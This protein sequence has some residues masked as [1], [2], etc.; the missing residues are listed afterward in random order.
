MNVILAEKP[1]MGRNI[2]EA[3]GAAKSN[4]GYI[5]L[6]NGDVVTWAIGHII[7][8]KTPDAYEQYKDWSME[9]LPVIPEPMMSEVD[10]DKKDQFKIIKELLAKADC[11]VIATDPAREGEHIG[12]TIISACGYKGKLQRLWISDLTP[13]TIRTGFQQLKDGSETLHLAES[14]KVRAYADYWIGFTA[15]RFFTLAAQE[16][17]SEKAVLSAGRVQTPTLRIVYDREMVIEQFTPQPFYVI[18]ADM[19]AASGSYKA[20]W[21]KDVDEGRIYR[22]ESKEDAEAI[23]KKI[24][25]QTGTVLQYE[26]KQVKRYA[27]QLLQSRS[28]KTA[29]RK[30][31]G[32]SMEKTVKVLQS[33][34]DK[35]FVTYPRT[36]SHHLS[37]N[38]A[39][40]LAERLAAIRVE[41]KYKHLFPDEIRSLKRKSRFVDNSKATEHHAIIPTDINPTGLSED[42]EKLYALILR[43]TLAAHHPEGLDREIEVITGVAGETFYTKAV[44][45]LEDGWRKIMKPEAED[46][47]QEGID[48]AQQPKLPQLQKGDKAT[49]QKT[50]TLTGKTSPPKRMA[51]DELEKAMEN[52][53][54]IIEDDDE[55]AELLKDKGIGTPATRA[56]IIKEL[57][58]REYIEIKKSLVYLT[59]KGRNFMEL[60]YN[61]PLASI[62]LTGEFEKKLAEVADGK[63]LAAETLAEF[64][65]FVHEILAT[66]AELQAHIRDR[67][68]GKPL[69][70]NI[71]EVATCPSCGKPIVE[72]KDFYGCT[73][74]KDGCKVTLPKQFLKVKI[75]GKVARALLE[76]K[77]V[78]FQNIPGEYGPYSLFVKWSENKLQTRKPSQDELSL[79]SCPHC[80]KPVME[81]EKFYGCTGFK[82]GCKFTLPKEYLGKTITPVQIRKLLKNGKT[83]V[84]K[85]LT[86]KQRTFD[87]AL[88]YDQNER[89]LVFVK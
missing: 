23:R 34:Y 46:K 79:G 75:P 87:S 60:V 7:R 39:D 56:G 49:V 13:A 52:A 37:E 53:G 67:L 74:F 84:I 35:G 61:H 70:Q 43:H 81:K 83:D 32:F 57:A 20:Q 69:F 28:I 1:D 59:D 14:A 63:R 73:G 76:G 3:L 6:K 4:R 17:T 68:Q 25:G 41:S 88:A 21:F 19:Q 33:V 64:K 36:S 12:R 44:S 71:E 15:T 48:Q 10:P 29:A 18:V 82:E 22:F 89:R 62:E 45:V 51:E 85:G 42:E 30:E 54:K 40:Q 55:L 24:A 8:L 26:E 86:G 72:R 78:L 66:R 80:K 31:L 50:D 58:N 27:P 11:C 47:E 2:A 38:V 77:E 65:Q 9:S 5:E 16:V